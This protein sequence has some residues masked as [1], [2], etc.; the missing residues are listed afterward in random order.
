MR[1]RIV[2][3]KIGELLIER[4]II[5][6]GQLQEALILQQE[7]KKLLGEILINLGYA[8]EEDIMVCLTTQY[9]MPYLP[10]ESYEVNMEVIKSVPAELV[11]KYNF[12][13]IDKISNLLTIVVSDILDIKIINEIENALNCKVQCFVATPSSLRKVIEK[14]YG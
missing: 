3:K 13:P 6:P 11:H 10:L 9:G 1:R 12:V 7:N 5:T 8:T 4:D 2:T 14:Y